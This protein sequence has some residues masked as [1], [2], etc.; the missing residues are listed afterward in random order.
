MYVF[1]GH[2]QIK[3]REQNALSPMTGMIG[4]QHAHGKGA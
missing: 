3:S 1:G 2:S 4:R